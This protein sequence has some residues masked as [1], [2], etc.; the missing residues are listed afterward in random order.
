MSTRDPFC[1]YPTYNYPHT[2]NGH[3]QASQIPRE[4]L[5]EVIGG[6]NA[7]E[8]IASSTVSDSL[9]KDREAPRFSRASG[10]R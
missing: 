10:W 1:N 2:G 4:E 9:G 3:R 8:G 7:S 5:D 6:S